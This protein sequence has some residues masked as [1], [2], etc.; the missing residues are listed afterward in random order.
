MLAGQVRPIRSVSGYDVT[1]NTI[2]QLY[3]DIGGTKTMRQLSQVEKRLLRIYATYRQMGATGAVG[4]MSKTIE[5]SANQLRIM[6]ELATE[7]G[8]WV[9][10]IL[11]GFLESSGILVQINA[12]L[13]VAKNIVQALAVFM[14]YETPDFLTNLLTTTEDA[15]DELDT[16][17]GKLLSFDKFEALNSSA[18]AES[19]NIDEV[20]MNAISQYQSILANTSYKAQDLADS[21]MATLGFQYNATTGL[22]DYDEG[23]GSIVDKIKD[24]GTG[25]LG[26]GALLLGVKHPITLLFAS[27]AYMYLTSEDIRTSVDSIFTT[28]GKWNLGQ[29]IFDDLALVLGALTSIIDVVAKALDWTINFLFGGVETEDGKETVGEKIMGDLAA[30][31]TIGA[32]VGVATKSVVAFTLTAGLTLSLSA[33]SAL[34]D[35]DGA[36][37]YDKI[38]SYISLAL[39]GAGIGAIFGG[40][41]GALIGLSIGVT[42]GLLAD[43]ISGFMFSKNKNQILMDFL[44]LLVGGLGGALAGWSIAASMATLGAAAGPVGAL[45]GFAVGVALSF[46]IKSIDWSAFGNE[47]A[48]QQRVAS[49]F[50]LGTNTTIHAPNGNTGYLPNKVQPYASGGFI[51]DGIFTMNKGEIAGQFND[52]KSYVANNRQIIQGIRA[53]VYEGVAQAMKSVGG[54]GGDVYLDK[55]KVGKVVESKVHS[56]GV[57]VG[58]FASQGV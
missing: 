38:M 41:A 50:W 47:L 46:F 6:S 15:N 30:A 58:H 4:D 55:D 28:L 34:F 40:G 22:W 51:E 5:Q 12:G 16:L 26:W 20:L 14:G 31:L 43:G 25:I 36:T 27:L 1:E 3:Q 49:D 29:K 17:T 52:G 57:R 8:T 13:I 10:I 56:E 44:E 45:V 39:A 54:G 2:F 32:L 19:G 7:L 33:V 37:V 24:T 18:S 48:R 42:L 21:W 23:M 35:E 11:K 53:G 9:G